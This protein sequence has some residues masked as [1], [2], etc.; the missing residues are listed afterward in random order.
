VGSLPRPIFFLSDFGT[1]DWYVASVKSKIISISPNSYIV[2]VTHEIEP[3][4]ILQGAFVLYNL[5][6]DLS[7]ESVI[8]GVVD[9]GV[10]TSRRGIVIETSKG[11]YYVGPDNGLLYPASSSEGISRAFHILESGDESKTFHARDLFA[12]VSALLSYGEIPANLREISPEEL[13]K[14]EIPDAVISEKTCV[15]KILHSDRFGNLITNVR[16]WSLETE[17]EVELLTS[18]GEKLVVRF[19]ETYGEARDREIIILRGS[20]GFLEIS[21]KEGNAREITGLVPGEEIVLRRRKK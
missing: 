18:K 4:N 3:F 11:N 13:K 21:I 20:S 2:D 17:E 6:K 7:S 5:S 12:P 14:L 15:A 1:K 10:G 9:P 16:D 8:L 19:L